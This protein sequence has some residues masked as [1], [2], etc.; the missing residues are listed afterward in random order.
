[1]ID[2][3]RQ[4]LLP[5]IQSAPS[6]AQVAGALGGWATPR[7]LTIPRNRIPF[8]ESWIGPVRS[9][10]HL[11]PFDAG[12]SGPGLK[13]LRDAMLMPGTLA[14]ASLSC[15]PALR[16]LRAG[17]RLSSS[18]TRSPSRG[19]LIVFEGV[20]RAGKS[21]QCELLSQHLTHLGVSRA[22]V[23]FRTGEACIGVSCEF[24]L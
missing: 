24:G 8:F 19:A 10:R 7:A 22:W 11:V 6:A 12:D 3:A 15:L 23:R 9:G 4:L 20:D 17:A 14:R 16:V 13:P 2:E 1:M 18:M 21:T 5:S